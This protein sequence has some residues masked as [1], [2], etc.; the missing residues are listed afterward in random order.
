MQLHRDMYNSNEYGPA[1]NPFNTEQ[2]IDRGA[3]FFGDLV[4]TYGRDKA[5][6]IYNI[7]ETNY[8]KGRLVSEG[9]SYA[10]K[11]KSIRAINVYS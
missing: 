10:Q 11:V 6:I 1:I 5:F 4:H 2:A 7:G 9:A 8:R 3:A